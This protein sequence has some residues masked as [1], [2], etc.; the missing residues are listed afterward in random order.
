MLLQGRGG[1]RGGGKSE[2]DNRREYQSGLLLGG[3]R[4]GAWGCGQACVCERESS[5][6]REK[7]S[8][9]NL[10]CS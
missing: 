8:N 3:R 2:A 6:I 7:S 10:R 5:L 1:G 9:T 4:G